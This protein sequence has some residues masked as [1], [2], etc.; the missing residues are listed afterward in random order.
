M[1]DLQFGDFVVDRSR[2]QLRRG[3]EAISLP[4]KAFDLLVFMA[5][6]PGRLLPKSELLTAVW[7]DAFVE[8]SNLTQNV[9]LLRKVL[10]SGSDSPILTVPGRGYQFTERVSALPASVEAIEKPVASDVSQAVSLEAT[11]S[12]VTYEEETEDR[13]AI[14]RS[15]LAMVFVA[16][17]VVL[18]GVAGWL[19]WQR[20]E[21]RVGGPP[22]QVVLA[23]LDGGTGDPVLDRSLVDA[24][25]FDLAQSPFVTV[26][27]A[28]IV[29]QTLTQMMHKPDDPLTATLARDLCERTGSQAV[30]HGS[31]AR[32]G[33]HFLLNEEATNCVDGTTMTVAKQEAR[34][35]E[36][37]PRSI[38]KLAESLRQGV[39]ESRRTIARYSAP[40]FPVNTGSVEALEDFT[41]ATNLSQRGKTTDAIG[42][43]KQAVELDPKFAAAY[44]GLANLYSNVGD[45]ANERAYVLKAYEL[46]DTAATPT[47]L[48][49]AARYHTS[50]TGDLFESVR[51]YQAWIAV[52]PRNLAAWA[53]LLEMYRLLGRHAEAIDA[54]NH[55]IAINPHYVSVYYGL[56]LEQMHAGDLAGARSTC[57]LALNRGLDGEAIHVILL[58]V[59]YL[60][61]DASLLDQEAAWAA[62]HPES[63][64]VLLNEAQFALL[65]GRS[66]DAHALLD[67]MTETLQQQGL[68][69]L[70]DTYR[71]NMAN[72]FAELGE[73]DEGRR[74]LHVAAIDPEQP[75][76]LM[77]LV[78]TGDAST[79]T[80]MLRDEMAKHPQATLWNSV[81]APEIR[82]ALALNA[83]N[84]KDAIGALEGSRAFESSTL[85]VT[86]LRARAYLDAG[87]LAD[88]EAEFRKVLAHPEIDPVSSATPVAKLGLQRTLKQEGKSAD[89]L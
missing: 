35:R 22:V 33:E 18:V 66:A 4:A 65:D 60:H 84:P 58:R 8:E 73:V 12:R 70:A 19:G 51:N 15:P 48:Y 50:I 81:Y 47:R 40:L 82:A 68:A 10:G 37:L 72:M 16:A 13:I 87:R 46:R 38:D 24:M 59:A 45:Q 43:L 41:Q 89:G 1:S 67:R 3:D 9:F 64:H 49:I 7:P 11:H 62:T 2:R 77:A 44:L 23:D 86:V 74:L 53:G 71:Q 39:G 42:L 30:L 6:N 85:D 54:A 21:D 75:E 57:E 26:V 14:W 61:H 20:W 83:H 34:T 69:S 5:A 28:A 88:A 78:E 80:T 79:A 76:Q 52:Y 29:R 55:A 36:D 63:S 32:V 56:A 17:A 27:P 25:R 31:V